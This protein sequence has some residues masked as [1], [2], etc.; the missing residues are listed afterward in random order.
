MTYQSAVTVFLSSSA[1]VA[2]WPIFVE[3]HAIICLEAL[4]FVLN[5]TSGFSSEK[6]HTSDNCYVS[7]SYWYA[8]V[9]SPETMSQ[10]RGDLPPSNFRSMWVHQSTLP[11]FCSSHRLWGI[12]RAQRFL[13]P[14][15]SWSMRVRLPDEIF[16]NSC[17]SAYAILGSFLIRESTLETFSGVTVVAIRPQWSWSSKVL[18]PDMNCLNHL[19]TVAL[20]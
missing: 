20:D 16:M 3:K 13:T 11:H 9:S 1:M 7:G 18:A 2:T 5:F 8:Q 17:I 14:R 10:T 19:K 6:T 15:Q 12:Q 4:L